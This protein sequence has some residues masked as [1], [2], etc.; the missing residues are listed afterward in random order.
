MD[1]SAMPRQKEKDGRRECRGPVLSLT[2]GP[3]IRLRYE[4]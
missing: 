1:F 2:R 4:L 3:A